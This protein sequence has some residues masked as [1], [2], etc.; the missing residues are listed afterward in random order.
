M[1][2]KNLV[3]K[4]LELG[5]AYIQ[6]IEG[7]IPMKPNL[8]T[9]DREKLDK[10]IRLAEIYIKIAKRLEEKADVGMATDDDLNLLDD[11]AREV[12]WT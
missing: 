8:C 6:G 10:A 4:A 1:T 7:T 5:R 11:L 2:S 3:V 12:E 9:P